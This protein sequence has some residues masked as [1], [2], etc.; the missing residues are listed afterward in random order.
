VP[1]V[2]AGAKITVEQVLGDRGESVPWKGK[3]EV[4]RDQGVVQGEGTKELDRVSRR[5][6][7]LS[8]VG[9]VLLAIVVLGLTLVYLN[10][11]LVVSWDPEGKRGWGSGRIW[12]WKWAEHKVYVDKMMLMLNDN[13]QRFKAALILY[14]YI[15]YSLISLK[16]QA[17]TNSSE[18]KCPRPLPLFL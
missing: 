14:S 8:D 4:V 12:R 7:L 11:G 17:F 15:E 1:I 9:I 6:G 10:S 3:E 16:T 13:E 5:G 18:I 2:L